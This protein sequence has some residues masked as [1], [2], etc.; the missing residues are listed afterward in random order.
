MRADVVVV[1]GGCVGRQRAFYLGRMGAGRVVLAERHRL[2]SGPTARTVE[3]VRLHYSH[4]PLVELARRSLERFARF[5]ELTGYRADFTPAG[6]LLLVP[7]EELE[8]L[9]ANVKLQRQLGVRADLLTPEEV[10]RLD[11][12]L[13]LQEVVGAAYEPRAGYADGYATATGFAAAARA[14]GVE[15]WEDTDVACQGFEAPE[16]AGRLP[17]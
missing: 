10:A 3:I 4:E 13:D 14:L 8:G 6:F 9:R 11:P 15:V 7:A 12:R 1:G 16:P 17:A 2:G 5:E